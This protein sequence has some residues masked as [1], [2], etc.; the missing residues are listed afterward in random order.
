MKTKIF[1]LSKKIFLKKINFFLIILL[2]F[3]FNSEN[4]FSENLDVKNISEAEKSVEQW[5]LPFWDV[6]ISHPAKDAILELYRRNI[7]TWYEDQTFRPDEKISRAEFVKIVLWATNCTDCTR[8]TEEIE[9]KFT[10]KP[11][12]DIQLWDWFYY[13]ISIWKEQKI[14]TWYLSDWLFRPHKNIARWEAVA[15]LLRKVWVEISEYNWEFHDVKDEYWFKDYV[16]TA[17]EIWL[18]SEKYGY[19][20]PLEQ[21]TRWEFAMITSNLLSISDCREN[22]F[23]KNWIRD[24]LE[25][26]D[27]IWE[28][29]WGDNL[30]KIEENFVNW[31]DNWLGFWGND[32]KDIED[33]ND[34]KIEDKKRKQKENYD[35]NSLPEWFFNNFF[36]KIKCIFIED[37]WDFEYQWIIKN[38]EW[39][40]FSIT[41]KKF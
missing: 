8:P 32:E 5:I 6:S 36:Q 19:V 9:N 23:D 1:L 41:E 37:I 31:I 18:I 10:K 35:E 25:K 33:K 14:I 40:I 30:S 15:I 16:K 29:K 7:I 13:C 20:N 24:F 38:S 21:I 34:E 22:D 2:F 26:E 27:W 3:I 39:K 11:F 12:D 28:W 17:V 4:I